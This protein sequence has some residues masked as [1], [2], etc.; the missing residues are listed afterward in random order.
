MSGQNKVPG[1]KAK[2]RMV[3]SMNYKIDL[4]WDAEAAVW[5]A[6]SEDIPGLVLESGSFDALLE[7]VRYAIPELLA[8]NGPSNGPVTVTFQSTRQERLAI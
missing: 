6:T 7:R 5:V 2:E 1:Q 3:L 8:L 4:T